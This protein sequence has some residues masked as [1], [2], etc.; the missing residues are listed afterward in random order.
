[1][2][3]FKTLG[4]KLKRVVSLKNV[5]NAATGNFTAVASDAKR[6]MTTPD[7]KTGANQSSQVVIPMEI[8]QE[9]N[10][11]IQSQGAVYQNTLAKKVASSRLVQSN[12]NDANSLF[13][14]IWWQATWHKNKTLIIVVLVAVASFVGW[15]VFAKKST[16]SRV[17]R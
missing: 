14:K 1:M 17:R 16:K 3:I 10:D 12:V 15:K 13:T 7:P 5:I 6:V 9:V 11:I 2:S 4:N 8:P